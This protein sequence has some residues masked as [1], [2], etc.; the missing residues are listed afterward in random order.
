[1]A[2]TSIPHFYV[3]QK[4]NADFLVAIKEEL[5]TEEIRITYND[6]VIRASAL[7]LKEHSNI[8]S[9]YDSKTEKIIRFKTI[10]IAIAMS[11]P[12]GLITPIIRYADY[13]NLGEISKE[14]KHLAL[15][16][17]EGKLTLQEY[18]GGS[19]TVSNLGMYGISSFYAILNP[20]QA[21]I[22][23]VGAIEDT[24]SIKNGRVVPTK[25]FDLTLSCD[26]RVID[27]AEAAQFIKTVQK[28]LENP[29][30][31]FLD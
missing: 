3:T 9:G 22:L 25:A 17:K 2:K 24:I 5:K 13:K 20:P 11:I 29:I 8:N 31:L 6:F 7:A 28:Y 14:S 19:F 30:L 4:V 26:H 21:A 1:M 16:A 15:R 12:Q 18:Q 10:D 27:G 23:S